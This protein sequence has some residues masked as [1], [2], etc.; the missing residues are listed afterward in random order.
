MVIWNGLIHMEVRIMIG[1]NQMIFYLLLVV[2]IY[3]EL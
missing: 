3:I 2:D 1:L